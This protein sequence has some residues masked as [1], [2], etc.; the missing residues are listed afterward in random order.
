MVLFIDS[1]GE[2]ESICNTFS[3]SLDLIYF[4]YLQESTGLMLYSS[5]LTLFQISTKHDKE[6]DGQSVS[7]LVDSLTDAQIK[8]S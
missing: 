7:C 4:L 1:V 2:T 8:I 3:F 6:K 5:F